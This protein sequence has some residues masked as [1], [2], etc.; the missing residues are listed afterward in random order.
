VATV[1]TPKNDPVPDDGGEPEPVCVARRILLNGGVQGLGVRPAI[2]RLAT[3]LGI[4]GS[5]RNSSLGV[6]I[7]IEGIDDAV[8]EFECQLL[9]V[10]PRVAN[11]SQ[12]KTEAIP[13]AARHGFTIIKEPAGK[14]L[15]AS[16]PVDRGLCPDCACE[17]AKIGERRYHYPFTS[18][19][20]CGPRYTVVRSMPFE[21]NDTA[22]DHFPLCDSCRAEYEQPGDRRFHAQTTA[23][24]VC[25]PHVSLTTD[26]SGFRLEREHAVKAAVDMLRAGRVLA[27]KGLGGYQLIVDATNEAGVARLR[28]LKG[29]RSKP[30]AVMIGDADIGKRYGHL[31]KDEISALNDAMAPIVL[32]PKRADMRLASGVAPNLAI[33]GLMRPTTPLHSM[34]TGAIGRPVVCSS[35]NKEGEPLEFDAAAATQHLAGMADAWIHHDREILRPIDDSVVRVI[36]Q[37]QVSL[38]LARGMAPLPLDLPSTL[39]MLALSGHMKA[40]VAWSNGAQSVLGP[41]IGDLDTQ[42]A[43]ERYL[44]HIKDMLQL[45]QFRP[46]LLIHDLHPD[47]FST[48]WAQR[49]SVPRLSVQH[50]HAH[51]AA[52]MLE[53]GWLG[54]RVLGVAWDGTGY[55]TDGTIW[56]GEFL[57]CDGAEFERAARIRPFALPGGEAAVREPW[58]CAVSVCSQLDLPSLPKANEWRVTDDKMAMVKQ[59]AGKPNLSPRTSSAGRLIDAAAALILGIDEVAYEGEAA[60]RLEAIADPDVRGWYHF[61]MVEDEVAELDWRPM[62]RGL[63]DDIRHGFDASAL[64]MK[65]HRSL[66]HGIACICRSWHE[67]PIVLCGGVFQNKLLTELVVEMQA[68]GSQDLGLPGRIPPNDGGLAAGQLAIA[69]LKWRKK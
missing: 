14:Q 45:Y 1:L 53:H 5:V 2:F 60:M 11:V 13:G 43:R 12:L 38:R 33:V 54:R 22:M 48:Q 67:L 39:P 68:N 27:L 24:S 8:R 42:R 7:E 58:R 36:A 59:L 28:E 19:T 62:F 46:R 49:Q 26:R 34:L 23:C 52:G 65:F 15:R 63:L 9:G 47:Y 30:L 66:A 25:G 56:G 55:G 69:S 41:H 40:A 61:P 29:R 64:A 10:L 20:Q 32:V 3:E 57:V 51:V 18:C 21:R 50:H 35:A 4:A 31:N 16:L 37:R 44:A 17:I 6:E